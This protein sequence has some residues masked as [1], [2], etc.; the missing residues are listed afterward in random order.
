VASRSRSSGSSRASRSAADSSANASAHARRAK[1]SRP[2]ASASAVVT[3]LPPTTRRAQGPHKA[4]PAE[5]RCLPTRN[6]PTPAASV[7]ASIQ[8]DTRARQ[9]ISA[10]PAAASGTAAASE[11]RSLMRGGRPDRPRETL[12]MD[13]E[14]A[15][16]TS[17]GRR[18]LGTKRK[19]HS[20]RPRCTVHR[21][22]V[23]DA[24]RRRYRVE[25]SKWQ[26]S[27]G[28]V[29]RLPPCRALLAARLS[30]ALRRAAGR[31][32]LRATRP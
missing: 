9:R 12:G 5:P 11:W 8:R 14:R 15:S 23:D 29:G 32:S 25:A 13:D 4:R 10:E 16:H 28:A 26:R 17:F 27:Q 3:P 18:S 1:H 31:V 6:H 22:D 2:R 7:L 24:R 21:H 20:A 19:S 30:G